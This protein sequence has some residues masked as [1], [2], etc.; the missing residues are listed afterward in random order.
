MS[1]E[2]LYTWQHV[3][4][5]QVLMHSDGAC[6]L[7]LGWDGLD[8][9]LASAADAQAAF[10]R[11]HRLLDRLPE[12]LTAEFHLWREPD[13][14]LA[15]AYRA[16]QQRFI[17][18]QAIGATLRDAMADHLA[19]FAIRNTVALVLSAHSG[20][21]VWLPRRA[22]VQQARQAEGLLQAAQELMELLP[23]ARVLSGEDY[24][25]RLYQ[26]YDRDGWQAG[27]CA[28]Y[29]PGFFINEQVVTGKPVLEQGLLRLGD[30]Y[31][32][33]LLLYLYPDAWPGIS[34][35]Y[36]TLATPLHVSHVVRR[37]DVKAA[38]KAS[39]TAQH[40]TA[41]TRTHTGV[42][43]KALKVDH[44]IGFREN[45]QQ[46]N[47]QVFANSC[48]I[49]LHHDDPQQL[50]RFANDLAHQVDALGGQVRMTDDVQL[51]FWRV[52]QP[53][54]GYRSSWSRRDD[55]Q[56]VADALPVQV[57]GSGD[58]K[59]SMLRLGRAGQLVG[60]DY[61][62][63]LVNH[64]ITAA[65]TGAGKGV[66]KVA[67]IVETYPLGID[68]YILEVGTSY[69]WTVEA[70]GGTYTRIDPGETVVNPLPLYAAARASDDGLNHLPIDMLTG[71]V[72][73]LAFILTDA[74]QLTTAQ[75]AVAQAAFTV[76][77]AVP[78]ATCAQPNF[79]HLLNTLRL[80]D[81]YAN[82][83]AERIEARRMGDRLESFLST[84]EGRVFARPNNFALSEG[85]T[86]VDLLLVRNKAKRLLKFYLVFLS[87]AFAQ[88][89]FASAHRSRV[90]L[91]ELHEYVRAAPEVIKPLI[92]GLARMG[93]KDGASLDLVTQETDEIDAIERA[94]I[95]QC[96][97]QTF[98]YR[99]ADWERIAERTHMPETI[100]D[101]W[102]AYAD[103][104]GQAYRP[105]L[106]RVGDRFFDLHLTFPE[107]LLLLASS[108]KS[109]LDAKARIGRETDDPWERLRLLKAHQAARHAAA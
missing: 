68:W 33:V 69:Q 48:V 105:A 49:H 52:G 23:G 46:H 5:D 74:P 15:E 73:A 8:T 14:E 88:R 53:G 92:T 18:A 12:T 102:R 55:T 6:S 84:A 101:H 2:A 43:Q 9:E 86:G 7:M 70:L 31:T 45:V 29:D 85:I 104:R 107:A 50:R 22:L 93:R 108:D 91:D 71:T 95:N 82:N 72:E 24:L 96:P 100:R 57:Y 34:A 109:D 25:A 32:K 21:R 37:L 94:V 66:N 41:G 54:Q 26:S 75:A 58:T 62:E 60:F 20:V 81:D 89:A 97:W 27:R 30:Q 63:D 42:E 51:L 65:M 83:E 19:C 10:A 106:Q 3:Y 61:A 103:P 90:L 79:E 64:A 40:F 4:D 39:E 38:M 17:R 76:M 1:Y 67:Q 35:A 87:L 16:Q 28:P 80:A 13:T 44:E 36:T 77:Y 56:Q 59:P 99:Q 11:L 47:Y 98:L 78:D